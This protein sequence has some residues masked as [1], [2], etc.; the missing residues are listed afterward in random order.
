M[1]AA[2]IVGIDHYNDAKLEGC[3]NDAQQV[4]KLLS[5][6]EDYSPNFS[7][8]LLVSTSKFITRSILKENISRLFSRKDDIS[9]FYFAGHG[10]LNE[11]GGYLVTQ[12]AKRYDEGI[13]M[14]EILTMANQS[15]S[16]EVVIIL[17]CCH[18]GAFG[19]VPAI[20]NDQAHLREGISVLCASRSS[21]SALESRGHGIFSALVCE[22]LYGAASN[23]LGEITAADVYA[24]VVRNLGAWNQRPLFKCY[25]SQLKP[26]RTCNPTI[27]RS[28]LR[29]LPTLFPSENYE[30]HLDPSFEPTHSDCN[31]ENV[32]IFSIL[33]A[34][35]AAGLLVPVDEAH[36]YYAAMRSKS[37]RL[38]ILGQ[39]YWRLARARKI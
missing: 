7:C 33:K 36:M 4:Q 34:Y 19:S 18:S 13:S 32:E 38:T 27:D 20:S 5:K 25:V 8:E 10:M 3:V 15:E 12:D 11:L 23:L 37:C 9:V 26:L 1:K 6:N 2:L 31:K 21:E 22:A 17:D 30:Y 16:R 24:F 14:V 39:Y 28:I 29:L 35:R